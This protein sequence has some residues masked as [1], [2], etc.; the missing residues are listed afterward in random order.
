MT[1]EKINLDVNESIKEQL[2]KAYDKGV[3]D[4]IRISW[5][6]AVEQLEEI[7]GNLKLYN[8]I[9]SFKYGLMSDKEASQA[10]EALGGKR[11]KNVS[12]D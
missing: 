1:N 8:V 2:A 5:G 12:A 3:E 9:T 4:G 6:K 7:A 10:L 11:N